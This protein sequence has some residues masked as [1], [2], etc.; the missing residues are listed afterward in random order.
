MPA[1][2]MPEMVIPAAPKITEITAP[3]P[4]NTKNCLC[5]V[6]NESQ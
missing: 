6:L 5:K 3:E 4:P 1:A 2:P